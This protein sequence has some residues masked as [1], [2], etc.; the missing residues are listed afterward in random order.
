M[1]TKNKRCLHCNRNIVIPAWNKTRRFCSKKCWG[2]YRI[3]KKRSKE[4]RENISKATVGKYVREQSHK[5][6]GGKTKNGNYFCIRLPEDR[7]ERKSRYI[8]EHRL[9]MEKH[10]G[11][12]LKRTEIVHHINGNKLD[13]RIENLTLF[14]NSVTHSYYH[15]P[16]GSLIGKNLHLK[17]VD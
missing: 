13:N 10:L 16:K 17:V 14:K 6:K 2:F 4:V 15:H 9:I 5:W 1:K 12:R 8:L 7:K 11:R 3:G